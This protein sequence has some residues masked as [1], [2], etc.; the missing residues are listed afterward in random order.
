MVSDATDSNSDT[1]FCVT[2]SGQY[3]SKIILRH[4][5]ITFIKNLRNIK[6]M[7]KKC[8]ICDDPAEFCI[9]N[10]SE[11][12]CKE[13]AEEHFSDVSLLIKVEEQAK[14]IK[15]LVDKQFKE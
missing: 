5:D 7:G 9:K 8:T 11:C 1:D 12:Y 13:C 10:S 4:F 2:D 15:E 3:H 6:V 14:R